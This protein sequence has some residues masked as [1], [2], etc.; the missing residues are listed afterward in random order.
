MIASRSAYA[1]EC[2][3]AREAGPRV[4]HRLGID[5]GGTKTALALADA[6]GAIVARE[7][8]PTEP[9]G[10][11]EDDLLRIAARA[12]ALA[13]ASGVGWPEV[14]AVGVS[15]PGPF[16]R[17]GGRVLH[18]PNLPGWGVVAVRDVLEA[19]LERPVRLENDANAAALAEWRYGAGQGCQNL[20]YLTMST[21][22]G[23][24]MILGGRLHVGHRDFAGEI[25]HTP[26]AWPGER[27]ACGFDGCLE[28]YVGGAAWQRRLRAVA[29]PEG[30]I[31]VR[32]GGRG[33]IRPEDAVAAAH[34]GDAFAIAELERLA[35][36][37]SRALAQLVFSVSPE[38][39]VLG[40]IAVA[41]GEALFFEPLRR[42]VAER[43]WPGQ[44]HAVEI[45]PASLGEDG[46]FRAGLCAAD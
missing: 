39:I 10:S 23:A 24:G 42:R 15:L 18:P 8:F 13:E 34:A 20:V 43:T 21:G 2:S 31:A 1:A 25:G 5:I 35:D 29:P 36:Y 28:A 33:Q 14:E 6:A 17:R 27:C 37:L 19:A 7:R 38:R 22:I 4:S 40:T 45:L 30:A 26:V 16:D 46:P 3:G 11:A 32:A 44:A 9:S 12:R 41:A